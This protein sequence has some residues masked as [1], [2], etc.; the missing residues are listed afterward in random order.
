M[1]QST[2]N[3]IV[4]ESS[5]CQALSL[6]L[7]YNQG[8]KMNGQKK[9]CT[10]FHQKTM[11]IADC[12][13]TSGWRIQYS[14]SK[15]PHWNSMG[16]KLAVTDQRNGDYNVLIPTCIY[17]IALDF[18]HMKIDR[19]SC[20][21]YERGDCSG[22]LSDAA[23]KNQTLDSCEGGLTILDSHVKRKATHTHFLNFHLLCGTTEENCCKK[24]L[25]LSLRFLEKIT[26]CR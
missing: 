25:S 10:N 4:A 1:C 13:Q 23:L 19:S 20:V 14:F 3:D 22:K 15:W 11:R 21:K 26:K 5:A 2:Q 8:H 18:M 6:I 7:E 17:G 24:T 16:E 9:N 12:F